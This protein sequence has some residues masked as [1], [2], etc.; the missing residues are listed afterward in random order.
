MQRET[1][2]ALAGRRGDAGDVGNYRLGDM[3]GDEPGSRLLVGTSDLAHHDHALRLRILLE[4]FQAVDEVQPADR[5]TANTDAGGLPEPVIG[6][7]VDGLVGEGAGAGDHAHFPGLVDEAGHDADLA[8]TRRN[9]PGAVGADQATVLFFQ[10]GLDPHH[11][12]HRDAFGDTDHHPDARIGRLKDGV[13]GKGRRHVDHAGVGAGLRDG[14]RYGVE[15][16]AIQM[17]LAASPGRDSSHYLRSVFN[18]LFGMKRALLAGESLAD[19]PGV[20]VDEYAHRWMLPLTP[21]LLSW[22]RR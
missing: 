5:V 3:I 17:G 18:A 11:V 4:E 12:Q 9:N 13:G 10:D 7:L 21:P 20:F 19:D 2:H 22:Q 15:D 1:G 8:L 14:V 6:G 16:G